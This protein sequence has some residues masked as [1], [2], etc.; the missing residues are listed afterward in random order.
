MFLK[1]VFETELSLLL[2][3]LGRAV[4]PSAH[5]HPPVSASQVL[6]LQAC[7]TIDCNLLLLSV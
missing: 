4:P 6:G 7:A 1:P 3:L 2:P 5:I